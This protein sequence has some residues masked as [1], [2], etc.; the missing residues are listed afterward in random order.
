MMTRGSMPKSVGSG[1]GN[2]KGGKVKFKK[3]ADQFGGVQKKMSTKT[4]SKR[5]KK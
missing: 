2:K 5:K 3:E 4:K 1:C